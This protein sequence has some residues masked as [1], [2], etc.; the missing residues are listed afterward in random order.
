VHGLRRGRDPLAGCDCSVGPGSDGTTAAVER[1]PVVS[2]TTAGE[3]VLTAASEDDDDTSI[4]IAC[5]VS[6]TVAL[7]LFCMCIVLFCGRSKYVWL[8]RSKDGEPSYRATS[9]SRTTPPT[10]GWTVC[11]QD[12]DGNAGRVSKKQSELVLQVMLGDGEGDS[13]DATK[14]AFVTVQGAGD[15]RFNGTY[16]RTEDLTQAR[17]DDRKGQVKWLKEGGTGEC[18]LVG[19]KE[20][21]P[22]GVASNLDDE[23]VLNEVT[24]MEVKA[25]AAASSEPGPEAG[26]EMLPAMQKFFQALNAGDNVDGVLTADEMG[27]RIAKKRLSYEILP[28]LVQEM[29]EAGDERL[30]P[31][32]ILDNVDVDD[33]G[34]VS[35]SA[36]CRHM[37]STM[38]EIRPEAGD[39][40]DVDFGG[41]AEDD[42]PD[43]EAARMAAMDGQMSLFDLGVGG[44]GGLPAEPV[45][46]DH[47]SR[48]ECMKVLMKAKLPFQECDRDLGL[49]RKMVEEYH[50]AIPDLSASDAAESFGFG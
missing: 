11:Q 6:A 5:A 46:A 3:V 30:H 44:G 14:A 1:I 26:M 27:S 25:A 34:L 15:R 16:V 8:L 38:I 19:G 39:V 41:A 49:L 22:G 2:T 50:L 35:V 29:N 24:F 21:P 7:C 13:M 28:A 17:D 36:L 33:D 18:I 45:N 32:E 23:V 4:V 47:M 42:A 40:E 31:D 9:G 12:T 20:D 43:E 10:E 37:S 48:V